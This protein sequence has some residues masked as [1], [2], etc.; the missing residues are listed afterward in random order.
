[1]K[2]IRIG[3]LANTHGL[4][5]EVKV[6]S[7]SDFTDLRFAK[8]AQVY[9]Q[10]QDTMIPLVI[11]TIREA[12]GMLVIRFEGY[13]DINQVE[14]WK[15]DPIVLCEEDLHAL[16]DEEA[17]FFELMDSEVMD[18]HNHVIGKV[19]EVIETGAHAILRVRKD[20]KEVLIPYVKAFI[21]SFDRVHKCIYVQ[22]LE[23]ML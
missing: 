5:G 13:S 12:K 9:L 19:V 22:L 15:G 1:M 18:Q 20:D 4:H 17:Y 10:H 21:Q 16:N 11:E 6:K 14:C 23:G 8:G 7:F 2:Y 3:V